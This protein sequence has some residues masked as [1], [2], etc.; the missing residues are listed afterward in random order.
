MDNLPKKYSH[1]SAKEVDLLDLKYKHGRQKTFNIFISHFFSYFCLWLS[2]FNLIPDSILRI[3][4]TWSLFW[5][6]IFRQ[7]KR[8]EFILPL[9]SNSVYFQQTFMTEF[10]FLARTKILW[11]PGASILWPD[12]GY[13]LFTKTMTDHWQQAL[14]MMFWFQDILKFQ[15]VT[16]NLHL[17]EPIQNANFKC[18]PFP[19]G[20][21]KT[22]KSNNSPKNC[23][24]LV[25]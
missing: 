21:N 9:T 7:V 16:Q 25:Y 19:T 13:G 20:G 11:K 2:H 17:E 8:Y 18:H 4:A 23:S 12:N 22:H 3:I 10:P 15:V 14:H 24:C 5:F 6:F 1:T